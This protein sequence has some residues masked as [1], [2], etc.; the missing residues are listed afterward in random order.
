MLI[1]PQHDSSIANV[2]NIRCIRAEKE[3][4]NFHFDRRLEISFVDQQNIFSNS[5]I[6]FLTGH[7]K[8]KYPAFHLSGSEK[9]AFKI[10]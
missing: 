8:M 1:N 9:F 6:D 4:P 7:H 3:N 10:D 2:L 5:N